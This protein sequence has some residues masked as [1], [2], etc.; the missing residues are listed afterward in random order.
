MD[1]ENK[2]GEV[3]NFNFPSKPEKADFCK[4]STV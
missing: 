3:V 2:G 4:V 1:I